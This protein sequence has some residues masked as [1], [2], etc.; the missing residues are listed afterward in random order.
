MNSGKGNSVKANMALG[1]LAKIAILPIWLI[2]RD[3]KICKKEHILGKKY[4]AETRDFMSLYNT[5]KY[6]GK[7]K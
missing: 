6:L 4:F 2:L 3:Y 5:K 7:R 1:Y